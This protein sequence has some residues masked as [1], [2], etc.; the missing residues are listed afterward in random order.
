M[1]LKH[2]SLAAGLLLGTAGAAAAAPAVV[3]G[4]LNLRS[5]PGTGYAVI[6]TMPAGATVNVLGCGGSWC[7]VVW[8]GTRGF[9]SRSYLDRMGPVYAAE[10]PPP[11][12]FLP[13]PAV[14]FGFGWGGG[15]HRGWHGHHHRGW[16]HRHW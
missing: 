1:Q 9:A 15:W 12:V 10:P 4:D 5:G 11:P 8:G 14:S 6:D 7:R 2:F 3:T 16:R 13:P